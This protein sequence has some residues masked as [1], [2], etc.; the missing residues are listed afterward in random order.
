MDETVELFVLEYWP[1]MERTPEERLWLSILLLS[2]Y[3]LVNGSK[4][5]QKTA[6]AWIFNEE[7]SYFNDAAESLG[8]NPNKL[9]AKIKGLIF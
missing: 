8:Y 1:H 6:Y 7:N 3:D 2:I 9:R 5:N 4:R